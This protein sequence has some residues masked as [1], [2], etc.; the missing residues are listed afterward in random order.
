MFLLIT[1]SAKSSSSMLDIYYEKQLLQEEFDIKLK[2][3]QNL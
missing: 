2:E 1:I 3:K